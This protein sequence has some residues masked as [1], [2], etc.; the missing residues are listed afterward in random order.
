MDL[1]TETSIFVE[2]SESTATEVPILGYKLYMSQGT[3]EFTL[4][5]S[6]LNPLVR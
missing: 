4:I 6:E 1:S 3:S 5:Y 2:W